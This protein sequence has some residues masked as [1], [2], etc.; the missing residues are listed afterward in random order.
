VR[1]QVKSSQG[2]ETKVEAFYI[3][4]SSKCWKKSAKAQEETDLS[5][6]S[7]RNTRQSL[8]LT[9]VS[10][11]L[12]PS[13]MKGTKV[14]K[15]VDIGIR[16]SGVQES[17]GREFRPST[18]KIM[19]GKIR[20]EPSIC[21]KMCVTGI[22]RFRDSGTGTHRGEHIDFASSEVHLVKS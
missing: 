16:C 14:L 13:W 9:R 17:G 7:V 10:R 6:R 20:S 15:R 22:V 19:K 21:G 4:N 3:W 2:K 1:T 5:V 12:K 8:D 11:G 18:S